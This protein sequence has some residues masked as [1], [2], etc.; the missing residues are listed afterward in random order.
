MPI[1]A[2]SSVCKLRPAQP[3][4][5]SF[6][7][8]LFAETQDQLA[9]L[10]SNETLWASLIEMQFR[11]RAATYAAQY[12]GAED[13]ILLDEDDQ[14]I[15]RLLLDRNAFR[16]RVVDIA[17]QAA[18]RGQGWATQ[19]LRQCQREATAAGVGLALQV[20]LENPARRLYER[21]GFQVESQDALSLEMVWR[22]G[23]VPEPSE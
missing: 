20:N 3:E 23:Q 5:A 16:W 12:P 13:L 18:R 22:A 15:G 10:R 7:F 17:I 21:L 9:G 8:Q 1:S 6:L 2:P 11:G 4:D 14:P 19:V